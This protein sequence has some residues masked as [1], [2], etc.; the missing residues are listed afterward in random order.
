M[1]GY[2]HFQQ[3]RFIFTGFMACL[4]ANLNGNR[5][6]AIIHPSGTIRDGEQP[7]PFSRAFP[8]RLQLRE[9][10]AH[11]PRPVKLSVIF[12]PSCQRAFSALSGVL[13]VAG[14]TS[15]TYSHDASAAACFV[16]VRFDGG[17]PFFRA[18]I[19][20]RPI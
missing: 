13:L 16:P 14:I 10:I 7:R 1:P 18:F 3:A 9:A 15:E 11:P 19:I 20:S 12:F 6:P 5:F 2:F 4:S 8:G 17:V